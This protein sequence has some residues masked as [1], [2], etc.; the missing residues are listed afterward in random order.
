[1]ST[2]PAAKKAKVTPATP[3]FTD[4]N[5]SKLT[6]E[7]TPHDSEIKHATVKYDGERLSFQLSN[8]TSSLRV[9]FGVDDGLK[10][11]GKPSLC[12]EMPDAQLEFFRDGVEAKVKAA[13]VQNKEAWFGSIKPLPTDD[14]VRNSFNSR[15]REDDERKYTPTLK[16]NLN[17][18]ADASK[19]V[20]VLTTRRL[21][22]GKV[23]KPVPGA[24]ADI[25]RGCHVVP[26]LRTAGGVWISVN[27]KKKTFEYGLVFE[28]SDVLVIEEAAASSA[29]NLGGV[30][31]A[32]EEEQADE[33]AGGGGDALGGAFGPFEG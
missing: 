10:F 1:M 26:V 3:I 27:A 32:N 8:A 7:A 19:T 31:V 6:I 22:N 12:I 24:A 4:L 11:G 9:P 17:L 18:G 30:E 33:Q 21:A 20:R 13:A 29:F 16:A 28:A 2:G 15:V 23:S 5:L 25:T 14:V